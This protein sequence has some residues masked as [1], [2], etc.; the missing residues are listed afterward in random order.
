M[1]KVIFSGLS[2]AGVTINVKT[3]ENIIQPIDDYAANI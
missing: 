2:N 3:T 1:T